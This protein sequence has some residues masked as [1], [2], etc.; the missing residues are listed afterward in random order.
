MTDM[1]NTCAVK[2]GRLLEIRRAQV[3]QTEAEINRSFDAIAA[4][5]A[6]L[7][8]GTKAVAVVDWRACP[9]LSDEVSESLI[10]K[11]TGNNPLM[12]LSAVIASADSPIQ[13]LQFQR[14][15]RD[16]HYPNRKLFF[17]PSELM[18]WLRP[19]LNQEEFRRLVEFLAE[20][21]P[22]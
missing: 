10:S 21:R 2:I 15:I 16:T 11:M 19:A 18:N 6:K 12:E 4:Q 7:P 9:L 13:V 17:N 14:L 22:H 8:R 1:Q 3:H 20:Y 5:L